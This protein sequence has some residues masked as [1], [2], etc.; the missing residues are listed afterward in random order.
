MLNYAQKAYIIGRNK[1]YQLGN[2]PCHIYIETEGSNIDCKKLSSAWNMVLNEFPI[3]TKPVTLESVEPENNF[4]QELLYIDLSKLKEEEVETQLSQ[5]RNSFGKRKMHIEKG[6][7][8]SLTL[9]SLPNNKNLI[10]FDMDLACCDVYSAQVILKYLAIYYNSKIYGYPTLESLLKIDVTR[11]ESLS[12][13]DYVSLNKKLDKETCRKITE[14]T[15][16]NHISKKSF[17]LEIFFSIL[18]KYSLDKEYVI[19]VP[20]FNIDK[21]I[22]LVGDYT[23]II[24]IKNTNDQ[25]IN[26]LENINEIEKYFN[27]DI[28]CFLDRSS[29]KCATVFSYIQDKELLTN[30][31]ILSLGNLR[32]M[33]SQTP[34]VGLDCQIFEIDD[35][36][37]ID[38]VIPKQLYV[39]ER[40]KEMLDEYINI[41]C[42]KAKEL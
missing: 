42:K 41:I 27:N 40:A 17:Y 33:T 26:L 23:K 18:N 9:F 37:R 19:S 31:F 12:S 16:F 14:W 3:L 36:I 10:A 5:F 15:K 24:F 4:K 11:I 25:N 30:Q 22:D 29:W 2:V 7:C 8:T 20:D 28:S 6:Q 1:E 39:E 35:Y 13:C 38:F 21:R 32:F 34:E